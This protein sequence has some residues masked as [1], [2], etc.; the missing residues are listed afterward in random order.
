MYSQSKRRL[1]EPTELL[2]M[3][4]VRSVRKWT[5]CWKDIN[6]PSFAICSAI[7]KKGRKLLSTY[8][9]PRLRHFSNEGLVSAKRIQQERQLLPHHMET[10]SEGVQ[11]D[12]AIVGFAAADGF[13][14]A[15]GNASFWRH[16]FTVRMDAASTFFVTFP[17]RPRR[18][19]GSLPPRTRTCCNIQV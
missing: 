12:A 17:Y 13:L 11:V 5:S 7:R 16:S 19:A 3:T 9:G 10:L 15:D 1:E 6:F 4:G 14:D 18:L 8:S 2:R